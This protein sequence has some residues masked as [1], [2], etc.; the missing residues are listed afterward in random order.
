MDYDEVFSALNC[1]EMERICWV[2][3]AMTG[4]LLLLSLYTF[5]VYI[6]SSLS[7][8]LSENVKL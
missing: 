3:E 6:A 1:L 8:C 5:F 2:L 7:F 4:T